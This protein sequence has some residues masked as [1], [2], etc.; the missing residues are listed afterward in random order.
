[1]N[2]KCITRTLNTVIRHLGTPCPVFFA[3]LVIYYFYY[4]RL[5]RNLCLVLETSFFFA[6]PSSWYSKSAIVFASLQ[7]A[8]YAGLFLISVNY[9]ANN[10][11]C[12]LC[13]SI[14]FIGMPII[15]LV[16]QLEF[17]VFI[18]S[19]KQNIGYL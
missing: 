12:Q 7:D 16:F 14:I 8:L 17:I 6:F 9:P 2:F 19:L 1:M 18:L 5:G 13:S 4:D 11:Q 15:M 10:P 3:G